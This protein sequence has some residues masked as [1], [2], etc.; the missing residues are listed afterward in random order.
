M[1]RD[2]GYQIAIIAQGCLLTVG[3]DC[4]TLRSKSAKLVLMCFLNQHD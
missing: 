1:S 3:L 4:L 2:V